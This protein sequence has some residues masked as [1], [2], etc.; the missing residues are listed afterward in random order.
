MRMIAGMVPSEPASA[1]CPGLTQFDAQVGTP[2]DLP[3]PSRALVLVGSG[4]GTAVDPAGSRPS[5]AF[6]A[7]LIAT[8]QRVPQT[9]RRRRAEPS[10]V[11]TIYAAGSAPAARIGRAFCR[12]M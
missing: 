12:S 3:Q 1:A 10:E 9:R 2:A 5:A 11:S 6:L 8:A 4:L 7:Q